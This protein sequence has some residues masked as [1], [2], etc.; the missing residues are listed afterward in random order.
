M[1][2]LL[3]FSFAVLAA[4]SSKHS[5]G[6]TPGTDGTSGGG[7]SSSGDT[8]GGDGGGGSGAG[9]SEAAKLVYVVSSENDLYSF[10]PDTLTFAKVGPLTCP[11]GS[12]AGP[13]SMAVERSGTAYV[14]YDDGSLFRVSTADASCSATGFAPQQ[15]FKTFGMGFSTDTAGATTESLFVC[16][17]NFVNGVESGLGLARL[18]LT[19]MAIAPL[20]KFTGGLQGH[21]GELTGTGDA[22][23]YGFFE[24]SPALLADIDKTSTATPSPYALG[25]LQLAIDSAYA[26][27]FWGGDFW[28]Y[29]ADISQNPGDTTN[30]TRLKAATDNSL[31]VVKPQI[32]FRI[33]GAGVSTCA[34]TTPPK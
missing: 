29:T 28:F 16:G 30:V 10:H 26:F 6:F 9:C 15:G 21:C 17:F 13:F 32:G 2:A 3:F 18:N 4:C 11:A 27:S 25:G 31:G 33:V 1:R 34:P 20:G 23:L 5:T 14:N 8:F 12:G 19:T 7:G 22:K 24:G